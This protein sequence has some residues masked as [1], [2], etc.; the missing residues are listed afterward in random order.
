MATLIAGGGCDPGQLAG[1]PPAADAR[2][3][4]D[5]SPD[6]SPGADGSATDA[7]T[8]GSCPQVCGRVASTAMRVDASC[9]FLIPCPPA[10]D[11]IGLAV[12]VDS[13]PIP[14]SPSEG[15]DYTDATMSAFELHGQVCTDLMSGAA[16]MVIANYTC[17][18]P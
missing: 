12:I 11:F 17:P 7:G 4:A 9:V 10:G 8:D 5:V 14:R 15:W 1:S 16:M 3:E 13:R 6:D 18:V 2:I